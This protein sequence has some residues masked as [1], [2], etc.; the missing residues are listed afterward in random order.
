[1]HHF[2]T[3]K[4][5]VSD[6]RQRVLMSVYQHFY[7]ASF[8]QMGRARRPLMESIAGDISLTA[9]CQDDAKGAESEEKDHDDTERK[10]DYI[11]TD[12]T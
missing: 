2:F 6:Y 3:Y 4:R 5:H 8:I 7:L 10:A 9:R 1:M 12:E 11:M